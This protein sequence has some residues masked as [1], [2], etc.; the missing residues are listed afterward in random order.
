M[1]QVT[2]STTNEIKNRSG[3]GA[4]IL[5]LVIVGFILY[6]FIKVLIPF[7]HIN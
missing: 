4:K 7:M 1:K 3:R 2:H 5:L 6:P